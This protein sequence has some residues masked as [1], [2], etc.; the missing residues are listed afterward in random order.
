MMHVKR[1]ALDCYLHCND[2]ENIIEGEIAINFCSEK[3]KI[4]S[5][6]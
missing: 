3:A 4:L 1:I 5:L 2:N 6:I